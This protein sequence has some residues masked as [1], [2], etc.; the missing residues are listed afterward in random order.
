M[1]MNKRNLHFFLIITVILCF[2]SSAY[3]HPHMF[4]DV[5]AKFMI[6]DTALSGFYV[7]WDFDEMNSTMIIDDFDAN[8]NGRF[9]KVEYQNI[10]SKA[11]SYAAKDDYFIAFTWGTKFLS[12][13]KVEQFSAT[14]EKRTRVRY[15]FFI[16]CKIPL[17]S[18]ADNHISIFFDDPSM[19]VA[20]TLK[21]E[22]IQ[23]L[24]NDK[25]KST[26]R[27]GKLDHIDRIILSFSRKAH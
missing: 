26:V 5:M 23:A 6:N 12:I 19:Y 17:K 13:N 25:W 24:P 10:K 18:L 16:P 2:C 4:I 21:K 22:M 3:T 9:E 15:S 14:I 7:Y 11:F 1:T 8:K 27:F 20:F